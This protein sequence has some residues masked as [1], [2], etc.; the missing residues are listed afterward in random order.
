MLNE[1]MP[2][3]ASEKSI[4]DQDIDQIKTIIALGILAIRPVGTTDEE[5]NKS[6]MDQLNSFADVAIKGIEAKGIT[7]VKREVIPG[8]DLSN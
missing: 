5:K 3:P 1:Q 2:Q 7:F 4:R 6:A 8:L